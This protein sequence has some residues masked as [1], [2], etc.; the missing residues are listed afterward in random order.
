LRKLRDLR[1]PKSTQ[2]GLPRPA[3]GTATQTRDDRPSH[4]D[5]S[6]LPD[7]VSLGVT[8]MIA[9]FQSG[10]LSWGACITPN[11][12]VNPRRSNS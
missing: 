9:T 5:A 3:K 1:F 2:D 12:T 6:V 10:S 7:P 8:D 4:I 11:N